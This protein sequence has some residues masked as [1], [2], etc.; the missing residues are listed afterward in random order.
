MIVDTAYAYY[1]N[2]QIKSTYI[3]VDNER[4]GPTKTYYQSGIIKTEGMFKN[5]QKT[6]L[7]CDYDSLG[8]KLDCISYQNGVLK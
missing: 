3:Y 2:G 8:H 1:K 4:N 7:W 5:D 6:A